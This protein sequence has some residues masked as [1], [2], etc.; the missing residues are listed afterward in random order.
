MSKLLSIDEAMRT[1]RVNNVPVLVVS[2]IGVSF[3]SFPIFSNG[4]GVVC[5]VV[6]RN[7][8]KVKEDNFATVACMNPHTKLLIEY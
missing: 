1:R 3:S 8:K 4:F 5:V 7:S 6:G 2:L